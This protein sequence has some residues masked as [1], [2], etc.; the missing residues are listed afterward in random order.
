MGVPVIWSAHPHDAEAIIDTLLET[1]RA[2]WSAVNPKR[3]HLTI[4][5]TEACNF[6]CV[7]CYEDHL[8]GRMAPAMV[9]AIKR[10][11]SQ[12][13]SDLDELEISWFGGEPLLAT[14]I[15]EEICFHAKLLSQQFGFTFSSNATTNGYLLNSEMADRLIEAGV[16]VFQ[17]SLD[18]PADVHNLQRP[19]RGAKP[20]FGRIWDNLIALRDSTHDL[21]VIIRIHFEPTNADRIS[22]LITM[23]KG[24]FSHDHRFRVFF[25]SVSHL[26]SRN[27]YRFSVYD[28]K[29]AGEIKMKLEAQLGTHISLLKLPK[30]DDVPYVCYAAA[31]NSYVIRT[32][33][34]IAKCTVDL[35]SDDGMV[36]KLFEDGAF[37]IDLDKLSAWTSWIEDFDSKKLACPK[38]MMK[39]SSMLKGVPIHVA[40]K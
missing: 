11:I 8:S 1:R 7:Y 31:L 24:S 21:N 14:D 18:G 35:Y 3:L 37:K 9:E 17:I 22:E 39:R 38:N 4:L 33:G 6:D 30:N 28:N 15:I 2:V 25:K 29:T 23:V 27:D 13:A 12:R 5:P 40:S 19:Q 20:S 10:H 36:G 16:T 34:R 32:D 26:G